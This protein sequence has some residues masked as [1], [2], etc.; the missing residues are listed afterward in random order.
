MG[1]TTKPSTRTYY[2]KDDPPDDHVAPAVPA[3]VLVF[4]VVAFIAVPL[5]AL[6]ALLF[7]DG[8]SPAPPPDPVKV[9][10]PAASSPADS[11]EDNS[12]RDNSPN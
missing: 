12:D 6:L 10:P 3:N 8:P 1:E 7:T 4:L 5:L 9:A 11:G 2:G